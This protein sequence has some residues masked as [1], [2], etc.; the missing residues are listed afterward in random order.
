ML[1]T[2]PMPKPIRSTQVTRSRSVEAFGEGWTF[3]GTHLA[4][5][6]RN[7]SSSND[8]I[9]DL[10]FRVGF[11]QISEPPNDLNST[12]ILPFPRTYP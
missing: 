8:R 12:S 10:G 9:G 3:D 2:L 4:V 1:L 6:T 7:R 11:Q 5:A